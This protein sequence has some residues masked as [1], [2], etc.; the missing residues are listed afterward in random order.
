MMKNAFYFI[1]KAFFILEILTFLFW[2]FGHIEKTAWLERLIID[3]TNFK[4]YDVKTLS[5]NNYNTH[6]TQY[7]TK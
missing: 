1:L 2:L 6:I 7:L 4:I 5:T 3:K